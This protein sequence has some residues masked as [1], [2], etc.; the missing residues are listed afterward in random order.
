[1][2]T[3]ASLAAEFRMPVAMA[4]KILQGKF[5]K[6][7]DST[8]VIRDGA[9]RMLSRATPVAP[10]FVPPPQ[11][12]SVTV[13]SFADQLDGQMQKAVAASNAPKHNPPTP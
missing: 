1:M 11:P 7:S 13:N 6:L 12:P 4:T 8:L 10:K 3:V 2:A 5:G 9:L